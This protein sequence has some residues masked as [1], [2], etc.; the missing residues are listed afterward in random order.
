MTNPKVSVIMRSYNHARYLALAIESVLGQTLSDIELIIIDDA[1]TD[2]SREIIQAF[3]SRDKRIKSILH[4][5]NKGMALGMNEGFAAA[6]GKYIAFIDSDDIWE[7]TKLQRQRD[8]L[9][10]TRRQAVWTE[11]AIIDE[12]SNPTGK[13]FSDFPWVGGRKK[14]GEIFAQLIQGNLILQSSFMA[15][16]K[17]A[18]SHP[19]WRELRYLNDWAFHLEMAARHEYVFISEPLTRYRV[20]TASTNHDTQGY[21]EDYVK[22]YKLIPRRLHRYLSRSVRYD[23]YCRLATLC[24]ESG[25]GMQARYYTLKA[26]V[27]DPSRKEAR[28]DLIAVCKARLRALAR[29]LCAPR[30]KKRG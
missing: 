26:F 8:A 22:A 24:E 27:I 6:T 28:S 16:T 2:N 13:K 11:G 4:R 18:V 17:D 5:K 14:D 9:E 25:L 7:P 10:G 12:N 21:K 30:Y 23:M 19:F 29:I 1:S 15:V 3:V 20:H